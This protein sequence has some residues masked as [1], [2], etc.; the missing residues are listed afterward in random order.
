MK[1]ILLF[2]STV[3]ILNIAYAQTQY[4]DYIDGQ[5]FLKLKNFVPVK[6]AE[7]Y[8]IDEHSFSQKEKIS[9]Y[10]KLAEVLSNYHIEK[11]ERPSYYTGKQ[12]LMKIYQITFSDFS[13]VDKIIKELQLIEGIEYAE[14]VPLYYVDF[15]PND[16]QHTGTNKWYHTLV[17]SENAWNISLGS[18]TVKIAV[19]DNAVAANHTDY[20]IFAQRDVADN[21]N[22]PTPPTVYTSNQGWSHGTH[23]AG[24][25]TAD[26]NN[27]I[28]IASLGGNAELIAVKTRQSGSTNA[29]LTHTY[30][31]VQWAA[32]NGAH[33]INMSF[34]GTG[35]SQTWQNL[36]NSFPNIVFVAAAGNDGVTTLFYPAAYAN[37]ICVG[38]VDANDSRSSFS[39]YNG[40]TPYVDIASPGGFSNGGLL[41]TVYTTGG[42]TY[43][44]M[45]GTSMASPFAAGLMGLMLSI[46]PTLTPAQILNCLLTT[47]VNINQNIGPRIDALAALQCVQSTVTGDP[48]PMFSGVPVS[49]IEGQSVSFTDASANGG[50]PIT[51]WTWTFPGG[52]PGS[53]VGQTPPAITYPTAGVY[54]VTLSVT[55]SQSTQS[56][57]K[58]G[59]ITVTLQPFGAWIKQNS[60]FTT[61]ARGINYIS[62]VDAQTVWATA[63]DGSGNNANIQQ[64]TKTIN[65]GTTWTPGTINVGNTNLGI[66]M[67]HAFNASTAWVAAYPRA[68]GQ[69][70]G[71]WKTTNGGTTW[72]RQNTATYNNAASFTNVVHFWDANVGFAQGDPINGEFELYTTTN[73]GT[74]WTPVP[75][76]NIPNPLNANEFGYVRQIEVIGD[77]V[78]FTTSVGRI[79][80]STNK[81]VNWQV[82]QTPISDFGGAVNANSSAVLSFA[83]S[84]TGLIIDNNANV[85]KTTNSGAIWTLL[86]TSGSVFTNGLCFIEGTNI[87]FSTG[88]SP[89]GSSFSQDGGL[90]WNIID[91]DQHLYVEF[92]NPSI[93]WSGWFNASATQDGMWKWNNLSSAL[94]AD[95]QGSPSNI[96]V[97]TTVNFT[98]LTTGSTPTSW[99]WNFPGGTPTSSTVQN[100]SIVYNTPG[101]YTVSLTVDDGNGPTTVTDSA[102]L[103][104]VGQPTMPSVITGNTNPCPNVMQV[105]SVVN[106]PNMLY[107]WTLPA[108]W[109]GSSTSNSINAT[110]DNT[111][112]TI[113]V[114][115]D[116]ICGSSSPRTLNV[117]ILQGPVAAF[118]AVDVAGTVTFTDASTGAT[119]W[120]WDFGDGSPTSSQQNPV[121][122]YTVSGNYIV[123]LTVTNSCGTDIITQSINVVVTS[124]NELENLG[125]K[126]Y[127]TIA[128]NQIII[129]GLNTSS[130]QNKEIK[131]MDVLGKQHYV[132]IITTSKEVIDV[133]FLS[134][135]VYFIL[136]DEGRINQK[137]FKK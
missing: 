19:V 86:T 85:Y 125:I 111:S 119:S 127:P 112:G 65:G 13:K 9:N 135:G 24:L 77:N 100:P 34:G 58:T 113:S 76:A 72:T 63:Y 32:Q 53:F 46:N 110:N 115:A 118:S 97:G 94:I 7:L 70:G 108:G 57:T 102:H 116:N 11:F 25:A 74:T 103:T 80:H 91:T 68:A 8:R 42:N 26:I 12:E 56:L 87:A 36:I 93:G 30:Q 137:F 123:T 101:Y 78:W 1:K 44:K 120:T 104:V 129:E 73:G 33:I 60:G 37:V 3:F 43:A 14:K 98:D 39:N 124:I 55:N 117:T 126:I 23:V 50:N 45:S 52:T 92:K 90:T 67:I 20:T 105:Y 47:G 64:F 22:D 6:S 96:C 95:F 84:T 51:N 131:I 18:N 35:F 62:I 106:N 28:G 40:S 128:T 69:T 109:L 41:S 66:S 29:G 2:L 136:L 82:Y 4:H 61:A 130:I 15:V 134:S 10:P 114:T 21:D 75:A 17:G 48:I 121:H 122:T 59:Y 81:G 5:I 133:S 31:G 99:L 88:A 71:I 89:A 16:P 49:I 107:T 27:G 132:S 38:S 79:Y 54:D 83:S